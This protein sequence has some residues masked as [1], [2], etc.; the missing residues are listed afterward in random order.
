MKTIKDFTPEIKAKIPEYQARALKGIFDGGRYSAF[1]FESAYKAVC[2]Q[3]EKCGYKK[4][5]MIVAENPYEAQII[6]NFIQ[7]TKFW[8]VLIHFIKEGNLKIESSQLDSQLDSQLYSQLHSQLDSQLGSQLGS[9]LRSQLRSQLD[10]QLDSQLS[11]QLYSQLDSQLRSQLY[12]QLHSQL[13]SQLSSQLY[14]QL[15]SQLYSQLD[16]Q[17]YSQLYSQLDSQLYSQLDSQ[18]DSHD[19]KYHNTYLFTLNILSDYYFIWWNFIAK[20][21]NI[22]AEICPTLEIFSTA[23]E[24]S[25]IYSAIYSEL[26]CVVSKYPKKIYRNA[27]NALHNPIGPSVEWGCYSQATRWDCYYINGRNLPVWI[28][29]KAEKNGFTKEDFLKEA[30]S[31]VKGGIYEVMGQS[32]MM[33]LLG[34][35]EIDKR[36]IVHKNGDM[37]EVTLLK[38]KEKFAEIDNQPFAWVKMICPSTGTT[39][40]QG[41]EPHHKNAI[42]AIASLSMF[43]SKEYSFDL[44]S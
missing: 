36:T 27:S 35:V 7:Q 16:S 21:F 32:K 26:V 5:V 44:R 43:E 41:V 37:E 25:N 12:S 24:N 6:F 17:L 9:Q 23:Q 40:L 3:Y 2:L 10:S 15:D 20:E 1:N 8:L 33:T 22:D 14:S 4:P 11:S 34:A 13:S 42:D 38:T 31:E 19:I 30:N 28:W 39:Y 29:Q 18:L